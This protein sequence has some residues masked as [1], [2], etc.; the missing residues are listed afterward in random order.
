MTRGRRS[1]RAGFSL[2]ELLVALAIFALAA[3]ALLSLAG[4]NARTAQHLEIRAL[5][6]IV[7]SNL[8]VEARTA[9]GAPTSDAG[10]LELAG[11]RWLWSREAIVTDDP[12]LVRFDIRVRPEDAPQGA[13]SAS[14]TMFRSA[15]P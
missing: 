1:A 6:G 10:A 11:R 5:A 8:A 4:E 15:A 7:A 13:V 3:V 2:L 14:L 12:D 9:P